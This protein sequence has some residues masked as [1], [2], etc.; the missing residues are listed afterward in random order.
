MNDTIIKNS[1]LCKD[2]KYF[3]RF[4]FGTELSVCKR[5]RGQEWSELSPVTG[6]ILHIKGVR[7]FCDNE[8]RY[9]KCGLTGSFFEPSL[10]YKVKSFIKRF[11]FKN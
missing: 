7:I 6:K 9:G 4:V 8:R 10:I 3:S 1:P 5:T 11:F 2:C